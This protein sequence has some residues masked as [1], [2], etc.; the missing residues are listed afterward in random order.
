MITAESTTVYKAGRRRFLTLRSAVKSAIR[1][2]FR[3]N[4]EC[5]YCD[6]DEMPGC[7]TE[8]LPCR[9]HDGS[10]RAEKIARRLGRIY[11]TAFRAS[12]EAA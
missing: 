11:V 9:L 1:Q 6:H 5:D 4:C 8:H 2:K 12:K 10:K 3:D 7:P